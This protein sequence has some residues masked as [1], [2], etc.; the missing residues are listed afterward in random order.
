MLFLKVVQMCLKY[1]PL[2]LLNKEV[3]YILL[4]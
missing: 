4:C 1:P 2:Y 3:E